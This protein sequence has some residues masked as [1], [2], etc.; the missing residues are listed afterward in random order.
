[1]T[2]FRRLWNLIRPGPRICKV[3]GEPNERAVFD[4]AE[5]GWPIRVDHGRPMLLRGGYSPLVPPGYPSLPTP[6]VGG[7]AVRSVVFGEGE[8]R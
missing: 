2:P 1:M 7:T 8:P 5:C 4:C 3:C 6:P